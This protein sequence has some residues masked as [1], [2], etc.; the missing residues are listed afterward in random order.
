MNHDFLSKVLTLTV[1][2]N[3]VGEPFFSSQNFWYRNI[4]WTRWWRGEYQDFASNFF[5]LTVSKNFVG[6]LLSVSLNSRVEKC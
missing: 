5:C 2:K 4:L 1:A 3:F 6:E